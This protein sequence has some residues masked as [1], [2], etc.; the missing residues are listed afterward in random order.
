MN[1]HDHDL[2]VSM[3]T[4]LD[5][6]KATLNDHLHEHFKTRMA[7]YVFMGSLIIGLIAVILEIR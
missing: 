5:T 3:N 1:D 7:V 6:L 2:I 4:K